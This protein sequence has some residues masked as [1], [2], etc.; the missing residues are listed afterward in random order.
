MEIAE[1]L[2]DE[3]TH[4]VRSEV[5]AELRSELD[6]HA[7]AQVAA[8]CAATGEFPEAGRFRLP[9]GR[10]AAL[11]RCERSALAA[12]GTDEEPQPITDSTLVGI[13]LD[14]FVM[15]QLSAGRVREPVS[16]LR[17]ILHAQGEWAALDA[18]ESLDAADPGA[19]AELLG[20]LA[21]AVADAWSGLDRAWRPRTQ[22]R[23]TVGLADWRVVCSGVTD[24]ELGGG[25]TARPTVLVEVKSGAPRA[26]HTAEVAYYALLVAL[27]DGSAPGSLVRWYPGSPP[28][29][30]AVTADLLESAAR[31]VAAGISTWTALQAGREPKESAGA[32]CNWC[33][34]SDICPT[35]RRA[36][37]TQEAI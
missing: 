36:S 23:A 14:R 32:W 20:P 28:A 10:L 34:D 16:D 37:V 31:R 15:H 21:S 8:F 17:S 27:R 25:S 30:L 33:G 19:A 26:E 13:A 6:S 5:L 12:A 24:V 4:A 29:V 3:P 2:D 22:S 7:A 18:L 9:K 35:G 11:G 1:W